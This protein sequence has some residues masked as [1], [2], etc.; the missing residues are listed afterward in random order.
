MRTT[1][2]A[3]VLAVFSGIAVAEGIDMVTGLPAAPFTC[4]PIP[5]SDGRA[6]DI[7]WDETH[8]V[9]LSYTPSGYFSNLASQLAANGYTITTIDTGIVNEDLSQYDIVVVL[10]TSAWTSSYTSE[11]VDSLVAFANAGGG[12][13]IAG[14]NSGCPNGNINPVSQAFGTTCGGDSQE[15]NDLYF[16]NFI[17]HVIFTGITELYHRAT[18]YLT[19]VPPSI[20]AAWSPTYSEVMLSVV[21]DP[22][23]R[24]VIMG[25]CTGFSNNYYAYADNVPF[26]VNVFDFLAGELALE[27][28]TWGAIKAGF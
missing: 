20:E 11:E 21:D 14:A 6:G 19:V 5:A 18:G 24:V 10:V 22:D 23:P 2:L 27:P 7:L 15:P 12:I 8:G 9:Y 13:L 26:S 16:T 17:S 3:L 4:T 1:V 28:A 25:T